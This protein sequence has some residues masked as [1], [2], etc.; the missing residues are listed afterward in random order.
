VIK[1][2]GIAKLQEELGEL[3]AVLGKLHAYPDGQHPDMAYSKPLLD[4][5]HDELGDVL[6]SCLFF[7]DNNQPDTNPTRVG[8]RVSLKLDRY[9]Q[10]HESGDHMVGVTL[11]D[12]EEK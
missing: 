2:F 12:A 6:A 1:W 5:L 8:D 7:V 11:P 9:R 4:R 3:Q 10:W